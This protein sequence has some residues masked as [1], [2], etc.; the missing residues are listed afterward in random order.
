MNLAGLIS[1][2]LALFSLFCG[3]RFGGGGKNPFTEFVICTFLCVLCFFSINTAYDSHNDLLQVLGGISF[4]VGS[5]SLGIVIRI[6]WKW[7]IEIVG[8]VL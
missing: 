8:I 7:I 6:S 3:L 5:F 1:L 2:V 4:L